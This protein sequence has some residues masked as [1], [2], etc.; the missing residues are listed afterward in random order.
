MKI[1][2]GGL[3]ILHGL[4]TAAQSPTGFN[5][6]GGVPN[7]SWVSWWPTNLGQSWLLAR[8]DMEKSF[9]GTLSGVLWLI[10]G[11]TIIAAG[12]GLF[13]VVVPILWWRILAGIGAA[14][15]LF[16]FIFFAHPLYAVGIG[17]NLAIL[18]VL[19]ISKWPSPDVLGS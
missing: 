7:P 3:L 4:I 15:S 17:A 1:F 14:I 5:P 19:L 11:I 13:G 18:F 10:A 12:L 8:I 9:L 2:V 16:V 6:T